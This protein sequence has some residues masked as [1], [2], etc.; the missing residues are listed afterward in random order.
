[1]LGVGDSE[2]SKRACSG[3]LIAG[4]GGGAF[5]V[6]ARR[7]CNMI[8][9]NSLVVVGFGIVPLVEG[10]C[11]VTIGGADDTVVTT[12][13]IIVG[14]NGSCGDAGPGDGIDD[15]IVVVITGITSSGVDCCWHILDGAVVVVVVVAIVVVTA[16]AAVYLL[17]SSPIKSSIRPIR[18]AIRCISKRISTRISI[19]DA[20]KSRCANELAVSRMPLS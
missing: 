7:L 9:A 6:F 13:T 2:S 17:I 14:G 3:L 1:M 16:I 18:W 8:G 19:T 15:T 5:R 20:I 11:M 12:G 4:G 10:C